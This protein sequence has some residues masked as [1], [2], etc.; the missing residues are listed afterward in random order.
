MAG[1]KMTGSRKGRSKNG[2]TKIEIER[3]GRA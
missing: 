3:I 2:G 1:A